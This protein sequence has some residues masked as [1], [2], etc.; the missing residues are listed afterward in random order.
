LIN[1]IKEGKIKI[2]ILGGELLKGREEATTK[3]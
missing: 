3:Q 2:E 1:M